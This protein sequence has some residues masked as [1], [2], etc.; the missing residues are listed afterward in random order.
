MSDRRDSNSPY[1]LG[2]VMCFPLTLRSQRACSGSRTPTVSVPRRRA[3]RCHLSW[4]NLVR[5]PARLVD[6]VEGSAEVVGEGVCGGDGLP[7]GLD[8][9]GAVA[10]GGLTNFLI[11]QPVCAS[12]HMLTARA[13]NTI[14]R[15]ASMESRLRW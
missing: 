14:M 1:D 11:D 15:C 13:A 2:G 6:G 5:K 12:I 3:C 4:L 8:L 9:D 10:A 7:S